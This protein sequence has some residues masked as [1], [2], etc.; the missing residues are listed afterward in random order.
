MLWSQLYVPTL[1]EDP[2]EADAWSHRLL[3]RAMK[4]S[5]SFDLTP[6]GLDRSFDLHH[7]A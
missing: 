3:L 5:Y 6:E 4:D 7:G 1:R 2:A